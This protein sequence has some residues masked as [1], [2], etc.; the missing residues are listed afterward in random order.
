MPKRDPNQREKD[1]AELA[2]RYLRKSF[3]DIATRESQAALAEVFGVSQVQ[4]CKDVK[5]LRKRWRNSAI[6]DVNE[7]IGETLA[8]INEVMGEAWQAWEASTQPRER[9]VKQKTE[10]GGKDGGNG[11][12]VGGGKQTTLR[13]QTSKVDQAGQPA[14]L[15]IIL[16][17]VR[18]VR[19]LQGLDKPRKFA[20]T[21]PDGADPYNPM[22]T[23]ASGLSDEQLAI[24]AASGGGGAA[25]EKARQD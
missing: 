4:I 5:E 21:S 16:D 12:G 7:G 19:E 2:R 1:L 23:I 18:Q 6:R 15:N 14:Y 11:G 9:E 8:H 3:K 10:T 13:V 22:V 20:P 24:I 25:A 17:C